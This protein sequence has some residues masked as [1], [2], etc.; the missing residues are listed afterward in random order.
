MADDLP[1]ATHLVELARRAAPGDAAIAE[2]RREIY[3]RRA[4]AEPSLMAK[5]IFGAAAK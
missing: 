5:G 1:L 3:R 4:E 2:T